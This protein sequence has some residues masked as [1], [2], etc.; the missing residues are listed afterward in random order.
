VSRP[1]TFRREYR[2]LE[3]EDL[4]RLQALKAC[5]EALEA[6]LH[7]ISGPDEYGPKARCVSI[8][9]TKLEEC[10]MWATKAAT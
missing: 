3:P 7:A 5:A 8:A 10:V 4:L 9:L 6:Q 2:K 1:D